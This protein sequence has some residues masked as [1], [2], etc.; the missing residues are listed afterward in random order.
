MAPASGTPTTL[1]MVSPISTCATPAPLRPGGENSAANSIAMPRKAPWGSPARN[2]AA[3]SSGRLGASTAIT[4]ATAK[5]AISRISSVLRETS[6][7]STA[8]TGAPTTTPS[9]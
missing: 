9:A 4:F 1:A 5:S 3:T 7:P 2:R 8:S 6:A